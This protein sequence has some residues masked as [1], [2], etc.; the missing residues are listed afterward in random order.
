MIPP[1]RKRKCGPLI[2]PFI[3]MMQ[4]TILFIQNPV[5]AQDT[6]EGKTLMAVFAH[7]DDEITL[8]AILNK[9]VEEGVKV[10]LVVTTD[11]RFGTN[12]GKKPLNFCPRGLKLNG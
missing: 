11:G 12:D 1:K 10:Y 3:I 2:T 6:N 9:Y 4:I 5:V 7:P 8:G